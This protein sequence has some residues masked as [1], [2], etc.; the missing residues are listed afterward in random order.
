[1]ILPTKHIPARQSL[2]GVGAVLLRRLRRP[3]TAAALWERV[4]G[5]AKVRTFSRYV[6][7][8]DL[9]HAMGAVDLVDG[10]LRRRKP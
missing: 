1:M 7:A 4:R 9:L 10:I 6:L 2:L 3:R 8:L 5:D